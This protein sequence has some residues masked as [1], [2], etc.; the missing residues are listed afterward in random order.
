MALPFFD[1]PRSWSLER[2]QLAENSLPA[3]PCVIF[4]PMMLRAGQHADASA[5]SAGGLR[6]RSEK[7]V[8]HVQWYSQLG[9]WQKNSSVSG[10]RATLP[11]WE[12]EPS[13]IPAKIYSLSGGSS[14]RLANVVN[15]ASDQIYL[16][17]L[18]HHADER[19]GT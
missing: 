12:F 10:R 3:Y 6:A 15:E 5:I 8:L 19:L 16:L 1:R 9:T 14:H 13:D 2:Q 18:A 4:A 17:G 11:V 7:G